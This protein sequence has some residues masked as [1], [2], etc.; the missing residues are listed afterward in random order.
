MTFNEIKYLLAT[1]RS[2][3][4]Y[5][6]PLPIELPEG[7]RESFETQKDFRGW[8]SYH[9]TWDVFEEDPWKCV[10]RE[11]S[12]EQ[13]WNETLEKVVPVITPEGEIVGAEEWEQRSNSMK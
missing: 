10:L 13:E 7:F 8:A 12:Q 4:I 11:K 6:K 1:L 3:A 2:E 9:V 5:N